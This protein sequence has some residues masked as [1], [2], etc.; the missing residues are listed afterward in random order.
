MLVKAVQ[1]LNALLGILV[2]PLITTVVS[3]DGTFEAFQP[4][5][6]TKVWPTKGNPILVKPVQP[7]NAL[8]PILVTLFGMMIS[9]KPVQPANALAPILVTLSGMVMLVKPMQP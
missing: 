9:V 1:P 6:L 3:D 7:L 5:I 4:N 8:P 2:P